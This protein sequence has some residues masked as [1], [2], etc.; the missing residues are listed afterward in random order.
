MNR[1]EKLIEAHRYC[2]SIENGEIAYACLYAFIAGLN[3]RDEEVKLLERER[4][5]WKM[6]YENIIKL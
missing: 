5:Y 3:F 4:D 6:E 2:K 1:E